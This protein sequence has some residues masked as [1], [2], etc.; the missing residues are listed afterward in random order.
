MSSQRTSYRCTHREAAL[1]PTPHISAMRSKFPTP[2]RNRRIFAP[3]PDDRSRSD[4]QWRR[5]GQRLHIDCTWAGST[6]TWTTLLDH[7]P[8]RPEY[9]VLGGL[10]QSG[11]LSERVAAMHPIELAVPFLW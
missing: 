3:A 4:G 7:P 6:A 2:W 9:R 5:R 1:L 8:D 11:R 10:V